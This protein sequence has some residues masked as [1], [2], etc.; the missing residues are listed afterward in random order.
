MIKYDV[1]RR[2]WRESEIAQLNF[3][4]KRHVEFYF[5]VAMCIFEPEF[6]QSRIAFVKLAT[7]AA[8]LDDLYDTHGMLGELKT[9]TEGVRR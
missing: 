9:I 6:S 2:W 7:V 1:L 8:V 3:Y 5:W 4:R